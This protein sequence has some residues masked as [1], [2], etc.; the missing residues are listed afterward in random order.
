[1]GNTPHNN[2]KND[3]VLSEKRLSSSSI[4]SAIGDILHSNSRRSSVPQDRPGF[5]MSSAATPATLGIL[6]EPTATQPQSMSAPLCRSDDGTLVRI[7][8]PMDDFD[9]ANLRL[10]VFSD[11]SVDQSSQ[12][13]S[14]S[15]QAIANR[16]KRGAVCIVA[17]RSGRDGRMRIHGTAECSFHE[18]YGTQL[19]QRRPQA[20]ILYITEV[21]VHPAVRRRGVGAL[22]LNAIDVYAVRQKIET[23][24]LHVDVSNYGAIALYKK[25]G[26][27]KTDESEPVFEEFTKSLNL[28]PGATKGRIHHLLFKDVRMATWLPQ[29]IGASSPS[30][31][32]EQYR[33][34]GAF[35]FEIPA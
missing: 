8:T 22:L 31:V 7:A 16:R 3:R 2:N 12:F 34:V 27:Q 21:A 29:D 25:C 33:A 4:Q 24:Y 11:F 28:Q 23:I 10:S 32:P 14:R 13:C 17:L 1:M 18:F 35:G 20:S 5:V 15:C 6:G 9:I 26:Y 19:G 30:Y